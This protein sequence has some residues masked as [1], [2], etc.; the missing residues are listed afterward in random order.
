MLKNGGKTAAVF[1]DSSTDGTE[2]GGCPQADGGG[3]EIPDA[4]QRNC[5]ERWLGGSERR[6]IIKGGPVFADGVSEI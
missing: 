1:C 3:T 4:R 6:E 2:G 5:R